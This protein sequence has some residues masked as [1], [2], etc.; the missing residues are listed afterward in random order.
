MTSALS[1]AAYGVLGVAMALSNGY[2]HR[3]GLALVLATLALVILA[4]HAPWS[5]ATE[6]AGRAWLGRVLAVVV[7]VGLAGLLVRRPGI[8]LPT[9]TSLVWYRVGLI[10]SGLVALTYAW[11][12]RLA[13]RLKFPVATCLSTTTGWSA[14]SWCWPR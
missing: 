12:G 9:G 3:V 2:L 5:D 8:Y 14:R 4:L 13:P 7:A 6:E 1:A 10:A 11:Q